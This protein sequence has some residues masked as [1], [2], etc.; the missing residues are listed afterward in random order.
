MPLASAATRLEE[1]RIALHNLMLGKSAVSVTDQN[2]EK[3]DFKQTDVKK[4]QAYIL[5]LEHEIAGTK[6]SGPMKPYFKKS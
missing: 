6:T 2:G 1:A 3:V 5:E 4:L